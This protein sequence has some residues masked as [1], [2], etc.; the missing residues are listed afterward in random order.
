M[1]KGW[2]FRT[3]YK[4]ATGIFPVVMKSTK[5]VEKRPDISQYDQVERPAEMIDHPRL[6]ARDRACWYLKNAF[7]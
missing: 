1:V 4:F 3:S 5:P 7:S 6:V 2:W